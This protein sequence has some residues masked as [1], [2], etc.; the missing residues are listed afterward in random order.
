[1][2]PE[3]ISNVVSGFFTG[4]IGTT[5]VKVVVWVLIAAIFAA[6]FFVIYMLTQYKIKATVYKA[7][8]DG[9]EGYSVG[10]PKKDLVRVL[11]DGSWQWLLRRKN[12]EPFNPK[13]VYLKNRIIAFEIGKEIIPAKINIDEAANMMVSPLPFADR[14]KAELELHQ[15]EQDFQKQDFWTLNKQFIMG[16]VTVGICCVFAG[17]VIWLAFKKTDQLIP[18]ID[19][20]G[21][22]I[23]DINTIR[24]KG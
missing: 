14:K 3:D 6:L 2:R 17:F 7:Y 19:S 5:I 20:F 8:G 22:Y 11:K 13:Y 12:T 16:A 1:M 15:L 4:D 18:A 23:K 10:K 9:K 21:N 24:G